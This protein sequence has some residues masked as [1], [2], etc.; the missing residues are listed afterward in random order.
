MEKPSPNQFNQANQVGPQITSQLIAWSHGD[1]AALDEVIR[2]VYQE[3]RR[4]A[5]RYLRR[6]NPGHTLQ[7]TALVHEA[8]LRLIDQTQVNWQNRAP[9]FGVTVQMMR[10]SLV[11]HAKTKHRDKRGGTAA[12]LTLDEIM[13]LSLGRAADLVALDDALTS[14]AEIDPRKSRMVELRFFGGLSVEET[15]EVLAVSPQTV[16]RYWKL[17][18]AWLYQEINRGAPT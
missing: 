16:L 7:P 8:W 15:A 13:N 6:E 10:R 1:E 11:D 9:F 4:M 12:K 5:D 3:L 14:L 18:K 17:A 2:T